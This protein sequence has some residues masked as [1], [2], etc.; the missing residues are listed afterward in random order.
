M[1]NRFRG[2]LRALVAAA[3]G[4][5]AATAQAHDFWIEPS[6][7]TP[8]PGQLLGVRFRVGERLAGEPVVRPAAGFHQ[9]SIDRGLQRQAVGGRAGSDPAGL[10]RVAGSG[11]QVIVYH[12][13]PIAIELPADK[14]T[15]YLKEEGLEAVIEHRRAAGRSDAPGRE[16]YARSAKALLQV[17]D[18]DDSTDRAQ[19][20]PLELVAERN[21]Y[22]LRIGDEL[23][24][25]LLHRQQP[26]AG[27]LV[28]AMNKLRPSEA[29]AQRS[30]DQGR[31]RFRLDGPGMWLIKAVHMVESAEPAEADW[32]SLWA[33]LTFELRP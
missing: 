10:L 15:P 21:P 29:Q 22:R 16:R 7:F 1:T 31:V 3:A 20:L 11:L 5:L 12:G 33:S 6:S 9:F 30:D 13:Q 14:F 26:L 25:Q 28:V 4:L 8:S 23:P 24:V 18:A 27:A 17:G 19:G 32:D 2:W